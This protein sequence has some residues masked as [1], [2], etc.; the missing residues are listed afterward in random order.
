MA[1]HSPIR[2]VHFVDVR[3]S[4]NNGGGPACLRL[5]VVLNEQELQAAKPSVF[6]TNALYD[7]LRGWVQRH[8]RQRLAPDDLADPKLVEEARTALDELTHL[9]GLGSLYDFQRK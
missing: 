3:Q 6:L 2:A 4:M 8:Y 9:L 1:K 5:R 7:A